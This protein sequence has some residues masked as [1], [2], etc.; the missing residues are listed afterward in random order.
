MPGNRTKQGSRG[1]ALLRPSI[2]QWVG[3]MR[4]DPHRA[5]CPHRHCGRGEGHPPDAKTLP[6]GHVLR[7]PRFRGGER[8]R[9]LPGGLP[10]RRDGRGRHCG[11]SHRR[12]AVLPFL[13]RLGEGVFCPEIGQSRGVEAELCSAPRLSNGWGKCGAM[14]E[15][16]DGIVTPFLGEGVFCPEIGQS[17]G[18]EAELCSAPRLSNGWGKCG[19]MWECTDGIV[20]PFC[21]S[22][23]GTPLNWKNFVFFAKYPLQTRPFVL[24]YL[25]LPHKWS[26]G[27][28]PHS[29]RYL[30]LTIVPANIR[31]ILYKPVLLCYTISCYRI[32]C[33]VY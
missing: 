5:G 20:T 14:W 25:L 19:A 23:N 29:G 2:I 3:K 18:V 10:V 17:R 8:S 24:Y 28:S 27:L 26:C 13:G 1:G 16:T 30:P 9:H 15:C 4:G 6:P 33:L 7:H 12:G 22:F 21:F 31:K 11:A 32:I